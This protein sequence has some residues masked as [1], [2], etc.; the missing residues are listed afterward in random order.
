MFR[1]ITASDRTRLSESITS[2]GPAIPTGV[3][4]NEAIR[5]FFA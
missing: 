2:L 5:E 1:L 3:F 4:N